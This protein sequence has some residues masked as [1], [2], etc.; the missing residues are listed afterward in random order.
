[1]AN[2]KTRFVAISSRKG[3]VGK[4]TTTILLATMIHY[5]TKLRVAIF[6]IDPQ[7]SCISIREKDLRVLEYYRTSEPDNISMK[8]FHLLEKK[9]KGLYDII[10][11]GIPNEADEQE[12]YFAT[13]EKYRT[14]NQYDI[15]FFDFPG[16]F[17][18]TKSPEF[19]RLLA[20]MNYVYVP[21]YPET[22]TGSTTVKYVN[23]L[24][25]FL[26]LGGESPLLGIG[27]FGWRFSKIAG[28]REF[29]GGLDK[30]RELGFPVFKNVVYD[31]FGVVNGRS[32]I[33]WFDFDG[34]KTLSGFLEEML[35]LLGF[36]FAKKEVVN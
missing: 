28:R 7:Q 25:K 5:R 29:E 33:F 20:R 11:M 31:A 14:S 21:Y 9:G 3:G 8:R 35:A 12:F 4:T 2:I 17:E 32:T 36:E 22:S 13:L 23:T 27:V 30:M 19:T 15:I 24:R 18:G 10:D 6:D 1:M 16:W 34:D 26:E